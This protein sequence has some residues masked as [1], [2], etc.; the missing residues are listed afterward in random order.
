MLLAEVEPVILSAVNNP[1]GAVVSTVFAFIVKLLASHVGV[2][3]NSSLLSSRFVLLVVMAWSKRGALL[4]TLVVGIYSP[5]VED[6]SSWA[7]QR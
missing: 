5:A 2:A 3:S 6:A 7:P 4:M 1:F